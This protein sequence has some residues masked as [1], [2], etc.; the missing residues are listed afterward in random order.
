MEAFS[1]TLFFVTSVPTIYKAARKRKNPNGGVSFAAGEK[2]HGGSESGVGVV[3]WQMSKS[4]CHPE[5]PLARRDVSGICE[6]LQY[7]YFG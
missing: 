3:I 1:K 6:C 4:S 2:K 7:Q 5:G